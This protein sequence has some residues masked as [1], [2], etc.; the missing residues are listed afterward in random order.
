MFDILNMD[1]QTFMR[2]VII[3]GGY[4]LL[5]GHLQKYLSNRELK[6]KANID[7]KEIAKKQLDDLVEDPNQQ[8]ESST[9]AFGWGEKTRERVRKQEKILQEQIEKLK[10]NQGNEDD[11]EDIED[12]LEK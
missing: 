11:D 5:R 8:V 1:F 2:L 7:E 12:L 10:Q 4:A 3:I 6:R 9:T